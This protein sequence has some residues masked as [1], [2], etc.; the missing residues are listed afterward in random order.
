M[1]LAAGAE[2]A[3]SVEPVRQLPNIGLACG[4]LNELSRHKHGQLCDVLQTCHYLTAT[5]DLIT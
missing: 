3:E 5:L 1:L 2:P 4:P